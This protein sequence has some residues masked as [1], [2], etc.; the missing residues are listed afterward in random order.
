MKLIIHHWDADG[1][2]SAVIY[3]KVKDEKFQYFTPEIGNYFLG[4]KDRKAILSYHPKEIILLDMSLPVQDLQF[5]NSVAEF[6][7]I[8]HHQGKKVKGIKVFNPALDGKG[9]YPSNTRVLTELFSLQH[10][11]LEYVGL[12]GDTG[13]KLKEDDP[14]LMEM[15]EFFG[16]SF[17]NFRKAVKIID[18]QYKTGERER[19][20]SILKFLLRNPVFSVLTSKE[21]IE[22]ETLIEEEKERE[23]KRLK[24]FDSINFLFTPSKFRIVSDLC[25]KLYAA[26]PDKLNIVIG[27][28][29]EAYNFYL[30]TGLFDL[31]P[32][33]KLAKER[34]FFAGGKKE[35]VG[36]VL[37]RNQVSEYFSLLEDFIASRG[38]SLK[39]IAPIIQG[40]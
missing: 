35:V 30:R 17:N 9:E 6:S 39:Q 36:A 29:G 11:E 37:D 4:E 34:G 18:L 27:L 19:V 3:T 25:R 13:F 1:I 14:L 20:I 22:V 21:F 38:Y 24:Q 26:F 23:F 15:K 32:L 16:Q 5:L 28:Q 40:F 8:D 33:V 2:A 7:V 12:F 10:S 31:S